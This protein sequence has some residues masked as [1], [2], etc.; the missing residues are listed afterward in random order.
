MLSETTYV[1]LVN[2]PS[3]QI[4]LLSVSLVTDQGFTAR[5]PCSAGVFFEHAIC[6]RKRHVETSGR[7]EEMGRVEGN[8]EGAGREKRKRLPENTVKMRNTP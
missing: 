7:E 8:G 1:S 2:F 6:S 3:I 4:I 5:L